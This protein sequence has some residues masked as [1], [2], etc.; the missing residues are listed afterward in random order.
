MRIAIG[1][2]LDLNLFA[3]IYKEGPVFQL[4]VPLDQ[5]LAKHIAYI[6]SLSAQ[7]VL[8]QGGPFGNKLHS[9]PVVAT[10]TEIE[11]AALLANDPDVLD[12]LLQGQV[13]RWHPRYGIHPPM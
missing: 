5:L 7:G 3:L 11:A 1:N 10:K 6:S 12:G 4:G 2:K 9:Y 8:I 13:R